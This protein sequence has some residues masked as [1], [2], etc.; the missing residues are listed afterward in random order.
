MNDFDT[1]KKTNKYQSPITL[2]IKDSEITLPK[3]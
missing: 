1:G 3:L 2:S